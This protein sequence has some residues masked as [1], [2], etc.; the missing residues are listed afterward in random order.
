MRLQRAGRRGAALSKYTVNPRM[1][2]TRRWV[3][4]PCQTHP[5]AAPPELGTSMQGAPQVALESSSGL[6]F[7]AQVLRGVRLHATRFLKG[8]EADADLSR[9]QLGLAHS[10]S[11][12]KVLIMP[13][14][15]M[16]TY[17]SVHAVLAQ[18]GAIHKHAI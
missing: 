4:Y 11:R 6:D 2:Q 8:L 5:F 3:C 13:P 14:W 17:V 18:G 9:S 7:H 16:L 10:Y 15:C 12:A 1:E